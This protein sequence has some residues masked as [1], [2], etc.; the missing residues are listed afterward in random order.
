[1][2]ATFLR[3]Y[4]DHDA[5]QGDED[6]LS[7]LKQQYDELQELNRFIAERIRSAIQR[8]AAVNAIVLL[9]VL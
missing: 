5:N 9:D 2:S 7:E 1:M 3:K 8:D 6:P 4:F